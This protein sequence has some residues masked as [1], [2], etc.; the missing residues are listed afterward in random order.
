F[1]ELIIQT[2]AKRFK[3]QSAFLVSYRGDV[4]YKGA[5]KD[6]AKVRTT[7]KS[8][9]V[10]A[11]VDYYMSLV[12]APAGAG[13]ARSWQAYDFEID[14]ASMALSWRRQFERIIAS[15]GFDRLIEKIDAKIGDE[16]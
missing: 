11:D 9:R 4:L 3:P 7:I 8:D 16:S 6:E 15:D 10:A 12:P 2:Y 1:R 14:G 5:D 13:A